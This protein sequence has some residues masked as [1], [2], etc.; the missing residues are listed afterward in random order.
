MGFSLDASGVFCPDPT[1]R[2]IGGE[3]LGR[4][5]CM[6]EQF[7]KLSGLAVRLLDS[8]APG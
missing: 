7:V 1:L 6:A 5:G 2:V 3:M 4:F 8:G